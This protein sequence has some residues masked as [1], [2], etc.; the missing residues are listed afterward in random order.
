MRLEVTGRHVS[1]TPTLRRLVERKLGKLD[2]LLND[3]A[4]SAQ[5][6][7]SEAPRARRA[8]ITLHAR[9]EHFLH[10]EAESSTWDASVGLAVERISQQAK[11]VKGRWHERKR[12]PR[13][14]DTPEVGAAGA[15]ASRPVREGVRMPTLLEVSRVVVKSMSVSDAVKAI[16]GSEDTPVIFRDALTTNLSVLFR[17]AS[18]RLTLLETET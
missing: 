15:R 4:V 6:V 7:L 16:K 18:G 2:R 8:D 1:I 14:P 17:H 13:A 3:G 12:S 11:K 9:G 5:V 10:G